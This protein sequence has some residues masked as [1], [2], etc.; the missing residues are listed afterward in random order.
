MGVPFPLE[1]LDN[2][3]D[4]RK[5]DLFCFIGPIENFNQLVVGEFHLMY[6]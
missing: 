1:R 5:R 3:K 2:F 6:F 4:I